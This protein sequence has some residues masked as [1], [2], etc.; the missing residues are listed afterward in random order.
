MSASPA[1]FSLARVK[2]HSLGRLNV[3]APMD[4]GCTLPCLGYVRSFP[5][6]LLFLPLM[7]TTPVNFIDHQNPNHPS[8]SSAKYTSPLSNIT[9]QKFTLDGR[10]LFNEN[11]SEAHITIPTRIAPMASPQSMRLNRL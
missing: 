7:R 6:P 9:W 11:A 3:S 2:M 4:P 5:F 8:G 10:I 1:P